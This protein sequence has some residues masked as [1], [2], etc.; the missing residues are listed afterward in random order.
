[1]FGVA[2]GKCSPSLAH[3]ACFLERFHPQ[4]S[5][6]VSTRNFLTLI[7]FSWNNP[8]GIDFALIS[9]RP[10]LPEEIMRIKLIVCTYLLLAAYGSSIS[11]GQLYHITD[12]GTLGG[13]NSYAARINASGQVVGYSLTSDG[14]AYHAFLYDGTMH[15]L[16]TLGTNS[17]AS[18]INDSGRVTGT[19]EAAGSTTHPFFYDGAYARSGHARQWIWNQCRGSSDRYFL[20]HHRP[21]RNSR[22][23]VHSW[24]AA[25]AQPGH[26]RWK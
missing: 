18:G 19:Y 26:A 15:D 7:C 3:H 17:Y 2:H 8:C 12:L 22:I 11:F 14:N 24:C 16:G 20:Q 10:Y 1:M 6:L 9:V 13:V 4:V 5:S 25:A 23:P 21:I